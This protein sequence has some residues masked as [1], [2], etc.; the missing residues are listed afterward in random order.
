MN[1]KE[2]DN[3]HSVKRKIALI[4]AYYLIVDEVCTSPRENSK[5]DVKRFGVEGK[6]AIQQFICD[7]ED[8][9]GILELD[10]YPI[11]HFENG[12]R[13]FGI[14]SLDGGYRSD[15]EFKDMWMTER[16]KL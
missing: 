6:K 2:D 16:D 12:N 10:P 14:A 3:W 9:I 7:L 15:G 8:Y 11:G 1:F 13:S 5:F 4:E